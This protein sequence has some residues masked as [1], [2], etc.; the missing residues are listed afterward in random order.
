MPTRARSVSVSRQLSS[1]VSPPTK[2]TRHDA[3]FLPNKIATAEAAGRVDRDR[4]L[5]KLM[6]VMREV[7]RC[8]PEGESVVYWMRMEDMRIHDNRAFSQASA[9]ARN[10][11][12]PLIALFVLSPQDY[13]AHD[14][15]PRR[16]DFTLRNL[17]CIKAS[18]A[19]L[20]IP[21][22]TR[23]HTPRTDIPAYVLSLLKEWNATRLYANIEYE[24]DEL[25]RD[26][27]VCELAKQTGKVACSF[28]HDKC[29]VPPGMVLTKTEKPYMVY[30]P[31]LRAWIPRLTP[32]K[33][34]PD[35]LACEVSPAANASSIREHP[36][37]G[38]L[39]EVPIPDDVPGFALAGDEEKE[40][41]RT[42]W[43]AGEDAAKQILDR[44]LHTKSRQSQL[45]AVDPLSDGAEVS[46]KSPTKN[47]RIGQYKGA[48][49]KVDADTTSRLSPYL[50]AGVIS[51]REC[52]R[53]T[54]ELSSNTKQKID[55]S[56]D[57]GVGR[58]VQ[59]LAWRDF[60]THILA[61]FPRVS[62]GR[63]F[64]EKFADIKWE[65]DTRDAHLQAWKDGRTGVPIVDAGM[66]QA[67]AMGWMHNRVRMITAS[68]LVKDL[69]IDWRLGEK[70]FMEILIDGDLASNNGGWQWSASTGVDPMPYFRI[71]NP[72]TQSQKAD[73]TGEYIRYFVPELAKVRGVDIH[74]P[75]P[76]LVDKLGYP[77][78]LVNHEE[79]RERA[80][81]RYKHPGQ[82]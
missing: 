40:R 45:G 76:S 1:A 27:K 55:V 38:K 29:I 82:E 73:P 36:V 28:I 81:R 47:S 66:R 48:R 51:A 12:I 8:P 71:F 69:M 77:R 3:R 14:R 64:Q 74:K 62:M 72:Y 61:M 34:E 35:P 10:D 59:E 42:C 53:A 22:Y 43:P 37:Y 65:E 9:Q 58:W 30:S 15:G 6:N 67:R 32:T 20:H 54:M 11:G 39:F 78:P 75:P 4:P 24:V 13:I 18:L 46:A 44:F 33:G 17:E 56:G 49:D 70:H 5:D 19:K 68:Y 57:T 60:Y 16:I 7:T 21:L 2:K 80:M 25:R 31:F 52:V 26:I 41:M 63:P 50:A 79:V 23:T